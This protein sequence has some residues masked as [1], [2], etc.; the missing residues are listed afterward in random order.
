M[1]NIPNVI[2]FYL[3]VSFS[4]WK[5]TVITNLQPKIITRNPRLRNRFVFGE[6]YHKIVF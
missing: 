3:Y 2:F 5:N 4:N 6:K 1:K